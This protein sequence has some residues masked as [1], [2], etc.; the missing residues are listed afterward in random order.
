MSGVNEM[1]LLI[2]FGVLEGVVEE[3]K[4]PELVSTSNFKG[5]FPGKSKFL[6]IAAVVSV[7]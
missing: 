1:P 6:L 3:G 2:E 7:G 4:T 5:G